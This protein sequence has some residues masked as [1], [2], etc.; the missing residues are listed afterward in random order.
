MPIMSAA[1]GGDFSVRFISTFAAP[2]LI[3][4]PAPMEFPKRELPIYSE[5]TAVAALSPHTVATIG[6]E[7]HPI[8]K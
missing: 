5:S 1:T 2:L 4:I 6:N 7:S 3:N 8:F